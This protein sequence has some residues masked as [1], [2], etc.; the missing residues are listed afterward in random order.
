[1]RTRDFF[2]RSALPLL[3]LGL[4]LVG[5]RPAAAIEVMCSNALGECTVSND[6][7]D[8]IECTCDGGGFGGTGGDQYGGLD[9]A[10][11]LEICLDQLMFCDGQG[12]TDEGTGEAGFEETGGFEDT[13]EGGTD[14]G[15]E[16]G[17]GDGDTDATGDG[18]G[19]GD[20]NGGDGDGDTA[21]GGG[22]G[23]GDGDGES[24][25]GD[26]DGNSGD[27]DG[28]AGDGDAGDGD[29]D[30]DSG[31]GD[32]DTAGDT[33]TDDDG[34]P[35]GSDDGDTGTGTDTGATEDGAGGCSCDVTSQGPGLAL[36]MFSMLG[37]LRLRRRESP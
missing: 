33:N 3:T 34:N 24:G 5:S 35:E 11:L 20:S 13:G 7:F 16:T 37:L 29:G 12:G 19:D 23:D 36:M 14:I 1:M 27:G 25:D 28:D 31:D 17:D 21:D 18:D 6:G 9:E 32:G 10:A 15:E 26:G 30:G 8:E 4:L 2:L 22:D